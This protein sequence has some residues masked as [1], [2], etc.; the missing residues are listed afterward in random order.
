MG[1]VNSTSSNLSNLL[2]TLSAASP[3]LSSMLATP[4]MQ[5]ALEK[6]SPGDLVQ[7]SDQALQL[8]Q[9]GLLFGS[10]DG[11]Q[12]S[13]LNSSS[14]S[15]FSALSF[16]NSATQ[17]DLMLQALDSSLGIGGTNGQ[18]ANSNGATTA[19]S[20]ANQIAS[21]ASSFQAQALDAL[22]GSANPTDP[23]LNTLG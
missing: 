10:T 5:I 18:P 14:D 12:S 15:L 23:S 17:P 1:S 8:Q 20:L 6:A 21:S 4:Q 9:V 2:Q 11:S 13:G 16:P 22:F 7:M 3:E 19:S